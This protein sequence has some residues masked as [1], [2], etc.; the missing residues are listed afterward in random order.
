MIDDITKYIETYDTAKSL[1]AEMLEWSK[2]Y[3]TDKKID[4]WQRW[5][6][7]CSIAIRDEPSQYIYRNKAM[8]KEEHD[9]IFT[10]YRERG[11]AI[12]CIDRFVYL[13]ES[14]EID[15]SESQ[16]VKDNWMSDQDWFFI[17]KH[18]GEKRCYRIYYN[19]DDMLCI[20]REKMEAILEQQM[21]DY[22]HKFYCNW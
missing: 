14:F 7:F 18:Y 21:S 3:V 15:D 20:A 16:H 13:F 17:G 10:R 4:V 1:T 5:N 6:F 22:V 2:K 12:N 19:C 11:E 9:I 8:N